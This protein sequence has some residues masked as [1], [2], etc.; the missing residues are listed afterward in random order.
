M[1]KEDIDREECILAAD[2]KPCNNCGE[3]LICDLNDNKKCNN[4]MD[5]IDMEGFNAIEVSGVDYDDEQG[6]DLN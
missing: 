4:C 2:S 6:M 3:C 1:N 5:C